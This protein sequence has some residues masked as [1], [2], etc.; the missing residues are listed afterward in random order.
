MMDRIWITLQAFFVGLLPEEL[1]LTVRN[2]ICYSPVTIDYSLI[3]L[4]VNFFLL[5]PE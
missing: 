1:Q 4:C 2:T 3:F 5:G